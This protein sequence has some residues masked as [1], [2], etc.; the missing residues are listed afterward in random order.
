VKS[1]NKEFVYYIVDLKYERVH[2]NSIQEIR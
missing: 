1:V 2:N